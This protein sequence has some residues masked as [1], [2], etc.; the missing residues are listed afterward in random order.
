VDT[1]SNLSEN[2]QAVDE[3]SNKDALPEITELIAARESAE[4]SDRAKSEFLAKMSHEIRTPM[5]AIIGLT[6]LALREKMSDVVHEHIVMVKQAGVNLLSIINDIL[7]FSKIESGNLQILPGEYLL[8]S[9]LNDVIGI[10]RMRAVDSQINFIV[11]ID[12]SLPNALI[13]DEARIRQ[14]LINILGNAVKYTEKGFVSLKVGGEIIDEGTIDLNI[15]VKDSGR[16]IKHEEIGK[17]FNDFY[18]LDVDSDA[19]KEGVGL[20]L[21][22]SWSIVKAMGGN[23]TVESEPGKGSAFAVTLRQMILKPG[24][25]AAVEDPEEKTVV[26]YENRDIFADSIVS[27]MENLGVGCMRATSVDRFR[28]LMEKSPCSFIFVSHSLFERNREIV[29][30]LRGNAQIVLLTE[31]GESIPAGIW[32]TLSMPAHSISIA[33]ILNRVTDSFMYDTV[34]GLTVRFSAPDANVLVVDDISTNLKVA[35][36]LLLP[37]KMQVDLQLSGAEAIEALKEKKY[38]VVFMDH[39]MP[40]MDGVE[41][42]KRIRLMG[43][44]DPYYQNLPIVALTANAIVGMREMFLENGFDDFLSKPIDTTMLNTV[45]EK[46]IPKE[47]QTCAAVVSDDAG[48]YDRLEIPVIDGLD[49][50]KGVYQTGGTVEYYYETLA[51]FGVDGATRISKLRECLNNN[52]LATYTTLVHALKSAAANIGAD[53]LSSL[54]YDLEMAGRQGDLNFIEA[55]GDSF[56]IELERHLSNITDVLSAQNAKEGDDSALSSQFYADLVCL[57]GALEKWDF[58]QINQTIDNL[59]RLARTEEIK[60][61]VRNISKHVLLFE[62]DEAEKIIGSMLSGK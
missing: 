44:E 32:S 38:D 8:S 29:M 40:D 46:W 41:T 39:R 61:T 58:E 56:I 47:K 11:D 33:N 31:F 26:V 57:R 59:L 45:L 7:D 30:R 13:G 55:N 16:G 54:A 17:L 25:L 53:K 60:N 12:S 23:I 10:I 34:K 19:A 18:Q 14:V 6:E 9:L 36:G 51:A 62:Y 42:T 49:T 35:H 27:T 3:T 5:N 50:A 52:D 24:R 1:A 2:K 20:G 48:S 4:R 37:Y 15:E 28:E 43:G 21:A 22:I